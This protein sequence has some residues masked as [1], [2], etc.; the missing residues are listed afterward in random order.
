MGSCLELKGVEQVIDAKTYLK[1]VK[2][3]DV[4]IEN[5]LD[6]L[7]HLKAMVTKITS[8]LKGDVVSG[9]GNQDKLGD[10]VSR[11]VDLENEINQAIDDYVDK[12]REISAVIEK[13]QDP[14]Q[15]R[16]LYKRYFDGMTWEQIA[17]DIHMTYRNVCYI[18]GR[19]LQAVD[20]IRGKDD[21]T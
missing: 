3:L 9:G 19:A 4:C 10:A 14:D 2:R 15:M 8:T 5:K 11:I 20:E 7:E 12:K 6:E 16:V 17:C 18:H 21:G 1:Q 13:V